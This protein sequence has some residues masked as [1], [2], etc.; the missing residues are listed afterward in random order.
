M[1]VSAVNSFYIVLS[2]ALYVRS[3][4]S[5]RRAQVKKNLKIS[6]KKSIQHALLLFIASPKGMLNWIKTFQ[7]VF[8][9]TGNI[10]SIK[11]NSVK[12]IC[13][14]MLLVC[15][16]WKDFSVNN[17]RNFDWNCLWFSRYI[18]NILNKFLTPNLNGASLCALSKSKNLFYLN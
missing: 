3:M 7:K 9:N 11:K 5:M 12:S 4:R 14:S 18:H 13:E 15:W 17:R 1:K 8:N 16:I 6:K 2:R 10:L